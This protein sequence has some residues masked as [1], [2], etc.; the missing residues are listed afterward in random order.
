M[1][2]NSL[3]SDARRV[4][5]CLELATMGFKQE[6]CVVAI[7][8]NETRP[9]TPTDICHQTG[10][11]RQNARRAF[12]ELDDA[13]LAER[14]AADGGALRKGQVLLYSWAVPREP[15]KQDCSRARLQF[16]DWFPDSWE[17][18]KP[19]ISRLKYNSIDEVAA[20]DYK[21]ELDAAARAYKE[22]D[23][24]ARRVLEKVCA[25]PK[26]AA[27]SLLMKEQKDIRERTSSSAVVPKGQA[28]KAEEEDRS[29][30][31]KF[32]AQYPAAHYDEAKAKPSFEGKTPTQQTHV[33]ERL[34]L[35]LTCERWQDEDG[36]WIPL[37]SKWLQ[38]YDAD[39]PPVMRVN[40]H[41]ASGSDERILKLMR[42]EM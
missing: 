2:Q 14:R 8:K 30:Y 24:V 39:P 20:R 5:A 41:R 13:G 3:S 27:V 11:S 32:K 19:L 22:A 35:Y 31:Q 25:R 16:P 28:A 33:L 38:S 26:R 34:A 9:L 37:A 1:C 15:K 7:G 23:I 40:R 21:E 42:G 36:R 4:Y 6:E 12:Q 29:L 17:P 10:L 18:L